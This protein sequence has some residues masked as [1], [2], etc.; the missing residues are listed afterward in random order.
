M[1]YHEATFLHD[2]L[3]RANE[4]HH[5]TALQAGTI[6]K[7]VGAKKLLVGHFSSRYKTLGAILEEAKTVFDNT[8]LA[9]E[10]LTFK[11]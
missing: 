7:S 4:T 9:T 10:G 1:L 11:I 5:T 3:D 6:A 2:M 8:E